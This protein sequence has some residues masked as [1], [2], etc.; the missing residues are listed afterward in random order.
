VPLQDARILSVLPALSQSLPVSSPVLPR[1]S[2]PEPVLLQQLFS[3][4][5]LQAL[6]PQ[7]PALLPVP[8]AL[9]PVPVLFPL[10]VPVLL[11]PPA[12]LPQVSAPFS[13]LP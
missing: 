11:P 9:L 1:A 6:L 12:S 5:L 8:Q 13:V 7:L 4:P 3:L 10:P 2:L